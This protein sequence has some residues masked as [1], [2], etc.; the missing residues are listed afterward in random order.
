MRYRVI[1][2]FSDLNDD[3]HVYRVGDAYPRKGRAAKKRVEELS[4]VDN[5]HGTPLIEPV[6]EGEDDVD[7]DGGAVQ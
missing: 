1:K 2:D 5:R 6:E 3:R 4:G 7:D